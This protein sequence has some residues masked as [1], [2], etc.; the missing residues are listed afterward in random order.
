MRQ[1]CLQDRD[2]IPNIYYVV[3]S[4]PVILDL[5]IGLPGNLLVCVWELDYKEQCCGH[6]RLSDM[7][8]LNSGSSPAESSPGFAQSSS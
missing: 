6:L 7:A 4:S 3:Q 2:R 5:R 1:W 8:V